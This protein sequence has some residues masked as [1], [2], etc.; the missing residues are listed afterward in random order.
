ML[1]YLLYIDILEG[2]SM[3]IKNKKWLTMGIN[4][5]S[6]E[7]FIEPKNN[8][9]FNKPIGGLWASP[10]IEN[11]DFRSAWHQWCH[12]EMPHWIKKS[13]VIF[14]LKE[15]SKVYIIDTLEDLKSL[16]SVGFEIATDIGGAYISKSLNFEKLSR[17]YDAIYLTHRGSYETRIGEIGLNGINLYGWDVESLLVLNIDAVSHQEEITIE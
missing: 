8:I 17:F 2:L 14:Q 7:Y 4:K 12:F 11:G 13:G 16:H 1:L 3:D 6:K 9:A 10:Y 15:N 5:I